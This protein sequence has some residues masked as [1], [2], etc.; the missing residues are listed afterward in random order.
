MDPDELRRAIELPARRAALHLEAGLADAMI[1]A[2]AEEPGGLPLLSCAL[3][4]SW[5]HRRGRTLTLAAYQQAGGVRG[6]VARLA[7]RAWRQLDPDRQTVAR[8]V[9]LRLAGPGEGEAVVRR[10]VPLSEFTAG[11]DERGRL[12]LDA[13]ADHRLLTKSH[14]TVEVAH[15]ALLREWPRLRGWL[16]EDVQGRALHRHLIGA[17]QEWAAGGRD[18]GELY[19]GARLTGALDWAREHQA[20][21]N[22]LEREF[23]DASRGA[24]EREVADARQRAEQ[25]AQRARREAGISR[26]LRAALAGLAVVLVL[27]LVAGGLALSLRGRAE[28]QALV[29]DSRHLGA[30]ALLED[31]LDRSLLLARQAVALDDSLETRSDLLAALLRSPAATAILRGNLEGIG[32]L[33][34][35]PNEQLLA[36][37]ET[38]TLVLFDVRTRRVFPTKVHITGQVGDL[39][40]SPNGSLLAF[41][42]SELGPAYLLDVKSGRVL[43]DLSP[44]STA[45]TKYAVD[46]VEFS[47][48][49]HTLTTLSDEG[50]ENADFDLSRTDEFLTRW[51]VASGRPLVGPVRILSHHGGGFLLASPDHKHLIIVTRLEVLVYDAATFKRLQHFPHRLKQPQPSTAAMDPHGRTLALGYGDGRVEFLDLATGRRRPTNGRHEGAVT[52]IRFSPDGKTL[53]SGSF[54][55]TV[56]LWDVASGQL[57]ETLQGH[58][59]RVGALRFSDHG[60]TL[61]SAGSKSIIAWDLQGSHRLGRPFSFLPGAPPALAVSPDGS[62]AAT[63]DLHDADHVALRS[64]T[65]PETVRRSL[66]PRLGP[67]SAVAFSPD[68]KRL[69]VGGEHTPTPVVLDVASGAVVQKLTGGSHEG[70]A[71]PVSLRFDPTGRRLVAGLTGSPHI[72]RAIVWDTAT[73]KAIAN[74]P[75]PGPDDVAVAWSP[76]G[77]TVATA[78]GQGKVILWRAADWAQIA[79]LKVDPLAVFY[80]AFSPDSSV[81]AAQ[82][83]A[84]RSITLWD[85]ATHKLVGRLPHPNIIH[86]VAFNPHGKTLATVDDNKVRL[87]DLASMRQIGP[88]LPGPEQPVC[89]VVFCFNLVEFDPSGNHL[90]ALYPSGTG[91]VWDVDPRLWERRACAVADRSLTR[92]EWRELLPGR[93]YQPACR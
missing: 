44:L 39:R 17:A 6:A 3:L 57:R 77:K 41:P 21:L 91:I 30:Q 20:D 80:V 26:R 45:D 13:L 25:E 86:S 35:S 58:E 55:R 88:A 15:E 36:I 22:Q 72:P 9:L 89:P 1:A 79:T 2:V 12:V 37:G 19:R 84:N 68:G 34:L 93:R 10:R 60:Q 52:S 74:L 33:E 29:A 61:Y 66:T 49:G 90:I 78:G 40:F 8:G 23:M 5:Q 28:H 63:P 48:D 56:K 31:E 83:F 43:R 81:I 85:V 24:A 59:A 46:G 67:I 76:D 62:L 70:G 18:P 42:T 32:P 27:A 51:D 4:E 92:E 73:G 7:E 47:A 11:P 64:I 87:W 38:G 50:A 65:S 69:A 14:D 82:G 53:A 16:E 71:Y 75:M 54:D